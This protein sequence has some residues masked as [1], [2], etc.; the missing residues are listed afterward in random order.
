MQVSVTRRHYPTSINHTPR[1]FETILPDA[2]TTLHYRHMNPMDRQ[3][4]PDLC[5]EGASQTM[6]VTPSAPLITTSN[7]P[8]LAAVRQ[9]PNVLRKSPSLAVPR[10][11]PAI[12]RRHSWTSS[13][14]QRS[15]DPS[16]FTSTVMEMAEVRL[17]TTSR[18]LPDPTRSLLSNKRVLSTT[19]PGATFDLAYYLKNTRP[20][21]TVAFTGQDLVQDDFR[22]TSRRKTRGGIFR[23]RRESPNSVT[24]I[25]TEERKPSVFVPP[26]GVEQKITARGM[27]HKFFWFLIVYSR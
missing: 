23:K 25:A 10:H 3:M 5:P 24:P 22:R 16:P 14:N 17:P 9:G 19:R 4:Q 27:E 13:R 1:N 20:P 15:R 21:T 8:G 11:S 6:A 2:H 18:G 7:A 26:E 12:S